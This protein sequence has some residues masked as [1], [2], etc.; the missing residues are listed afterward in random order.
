MRQLGGWRPSG[1]PSRLVEEM[2]NVEVPAYIVAVKPG[3]DDHDLHVIISNRTRGARRHFMNVEVSGLPRDHVH[4]ADFARVRAEIRA[5]LP[6]VDTGG[7]GSYIPINPPAR[8]L[9]Q[10]SLFFDGDHGAGCGNCPGPSW[11]KPTTVW[12]VHPVYSIRE[13]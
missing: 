9:I 8:V 13:Q 11:A 4:E 5:L 10:G 7:G 12:E 3:E 1:P 6:E 2:Q